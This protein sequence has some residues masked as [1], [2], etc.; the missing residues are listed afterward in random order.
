MPSLPVAIQE[1]IILMVLLSSSVV[2]LQFRSF[3]IGRLSMLLSA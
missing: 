2:G 1:A 3:I